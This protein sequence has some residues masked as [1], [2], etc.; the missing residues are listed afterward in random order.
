MCETNCDEGGTTS[1]T[2]EIN[3]KS[4][5]DVNWD[6][7]LLTAKR[8]LILDMRTLVNNFGWASE[9][10]LSEL[11]SQFDDIKK[12]VADFK[13]LVEANVSDDTISA[14]YK[15]EVFTQLEKCNKSQKLAFERILG[16]PS[17][18]DPI[19]ETA[20]LDS[21]VETAEHDLVY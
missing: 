6:R 12:S 4:Y 18:A 11:V 19:F 20:Q 10:E 3:A 16:G 5:K 7:K 15:D 17:E 2:P 14:L 9:S 21:A 1:P 8:L 13:E